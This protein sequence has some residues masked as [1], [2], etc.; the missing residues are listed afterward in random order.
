M[1]KIA[2]SLVIS[3]IIWSIIIVISYKFNAISTLEL[4]RL[5][6]KSSIFILLNNLLL[7]L[8]L[9]FGIFFKGI[10]TILLTLSN[11]IR[12]GQ[13][14]LPYLHYYYTLFPEIIIFFILELFAYI[15]GTA[16]GILGFCKDKKNKRYILSIIIFAI[17]LLIIAA[18]LEE[19]DIIILNKWILV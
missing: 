6:E 9:C 7:F 15:I 1:K 2:Y 14:V 18:C 10:P 13:I 12:I 3:F 4:G 5:Y 8:F 16:V 17:I 19:K 11:A